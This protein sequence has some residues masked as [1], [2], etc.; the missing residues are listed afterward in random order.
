LPL[1]FYTEMWLSWKR[2]VVKATKAYFREKREEI[3]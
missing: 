2:D 1:F 3:L